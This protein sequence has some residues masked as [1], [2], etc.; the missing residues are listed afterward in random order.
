MLFARCAYDGQT[1]TARIWAAES[2]QRVRLSRTSP[3]Q[4]NPLKS[5]N[6]FLSA[7]CCGISLRASLIRCSTIGFIDPSHGNSYGALSDFL[8]LV[9]IP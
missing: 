8:R 7:P 1:A 4:Q 6:A 2:G 3:D 5:K 9:S